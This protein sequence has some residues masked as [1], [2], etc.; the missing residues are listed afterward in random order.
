MTGIPVSNSPLPNGEK[1]YD[2]ERTGLRH[3]LPHRRPGLLPELREKP[4][5]SGRGWR[6]RRTPFAFFLCGI[7]GKHFLDQIRQIAPV[8]FSQ[9]PQPIFQFLVDFH[10]QNFAGHVYSGNL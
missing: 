9:P 7:V 2:H 3:P 8:L 6:A 10:V 5:P 4:R 1:T